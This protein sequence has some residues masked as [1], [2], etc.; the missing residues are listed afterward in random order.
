[1]DSRKVRA[2]SKDEKSTKAIIFILLIT[3]IAMIFVSSTYAKYSSSAKGT[4]TATVAKW[5]F[6]VNDTDIATNETVTFNLFDTVLDTDGTAETSV[7]DGMIAP[8]TQGSFTLE[9][10]N[11][12]EVKAQYGIDY[13]ITNASNVPIQY[14]VDGG[15]TW[16][17]DLADVVAS[18][19]TILEAGAAA[20]PITIQWQWAFDGDDATDT[21]LGKADTAPSVTVEA[22]ISASQYVQ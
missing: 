3:I 16:T 15:N 10:E 2:K 19:A 14:S 21:A 4:A 7:A 8:G 20:T 11:T 9:L 13:A 5:S 22:T 17:S 1:M 12:S 18:D 6:N